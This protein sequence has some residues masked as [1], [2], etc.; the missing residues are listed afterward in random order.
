MRW[1][2]SPARQPFSPPSTVLPLLDPA[3]RLSFGQQ[4]SP[5]A[6]EAPCADVVAANICAARQPRQENFVVSDCWKIVDE[7][8]IW[9]GVTNEKRRGANDGAGSSAHAMQLRQRKCRKLK[10]GAPVPPG[11]V[12]S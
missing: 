3:L 10:A 8:R 6:C 4:G 7:L 11:L 5:G 1:G 2:H 12:T 9:D